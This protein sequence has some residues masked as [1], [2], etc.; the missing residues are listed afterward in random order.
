MPGVAA[1]VAL[2]AGLW[3]WLISWMEPRAQAENHIKAWKRH[4]AADRTSCMKA[5]PINPI[6]EL[7]PWNLRPDTA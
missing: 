4:L 3:R 1:T 7:A 5:H 2:P 6:G